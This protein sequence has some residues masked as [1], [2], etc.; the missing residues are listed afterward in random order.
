MALSTVSLNSK[1][2]CIAWKWTS[3]GKF[4]V[5]SAYDCQFKRAI[6]HFPASVI[7]KDATELK[8]KFFTWLIMHEHDKAPTTNN[9]SKKKW[10]CNPHCPLCFCLPET[11]EH[12]LTQCN[13]V[14]ALWDS[15]TPR[16]NLPFYAN[17]CIHGGP[18][19]WVRKLLHG[20]TPC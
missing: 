5:A 2:D 12:L 9:L 14:E 17:M 18:I 16:Y 8:C 13:Y 1:K 20:G 3:N 10:S 7:W 19:Q 4:T 6:S 15:T 11:A